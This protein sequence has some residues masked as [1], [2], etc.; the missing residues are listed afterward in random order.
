MSPFAWMRT[1]RYR[2]G[3]G[4]LTEPGVT[5]LHL[6]S[7]HGQ[8]SP[9]VVTRGRQT[10]GSWGGWGV[11][12]CVPP[13]LPAALCPPTGHLLGPLFRFGIWVGARG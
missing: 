11:Q 12:R 3:L 4:D 5:S 9:L 6:L 2:E 7:S 8:L 13:S 10:S 1:L